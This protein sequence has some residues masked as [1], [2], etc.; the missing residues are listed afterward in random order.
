MKG[1]ADL[2]LDQRR[3][4]RPLSDSLKDEP[5]VLVVGAGVVGVST[6]YALAVRGRRVAVIDAGQ[7]GAGSSYGNA[8]LIVPSHS[9][10]LAMP[11]VIGQGLRWMLDPESP[12]YIK[13][14]LDR[15]LL[16]WLLKFRAA[17]TEKKARRA[18]PVLGGLLRASREMYDDWSSLAGADCAYETKGAM[19]LYRTAK[20]LAEGRHE[21]EMMAE[22]GLQPRVLDG[23]EVRDL[24]PQIRP[25]M[26]GGIVF[27]EDAH[28]E[29]HSFV[30]GLARHAER[31]GA[32]FFDNA[33][34]LG[35]ETSGRKVTRVR[36]T[37]GDVHPN[38][39][40]LATGAWT[41]AVARDL[42][43][44]IP[45]EA[46]KGYSL[47]FRRPDPCPELPVLLQEAKVGVTPMGP[48][49]RFA[50]TLELA[51]ID[52]S[53]NQRRV[54]A[55][56]RGPPDYFEGMDDLELV[57]IWRGLRPCTPD[58]LPIVGASGTWENLILAAGHATIGMSLGPVTGEIVAQLA[59]GETPEFD[60]EPLAPGRFE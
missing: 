49:L 28:L 51:G 8:G 53:I 47:T 2:G 23:R 59:C 17:A 21:I 45:I 42:D 1:L 48:Y 50:G 24:V 60:L 15:A 18:A 20:G 9:L 30:L 16:S 10:P 52:F 29:P 38:Q 58:G 40:V 31:S 12:F 22:A 56:R 27:P 36:T 14:R 41:P 19:Y 44:R 13:P 26:A 55:I 43:L 54:D 25:G 33:E 39:V 11:G 46:A 4:E 32:V 57:E 5:D 3:G 34:A 6:A 37:R 35:F 7:V